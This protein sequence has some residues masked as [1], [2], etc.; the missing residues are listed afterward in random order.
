MQKLAGKSGLY[1]PVGRL[2]ATN[3]RFDR[4]KSVKRELVPRAIVSA[5]RRRV[6]QVGC[7]GL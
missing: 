4:Q 6:K 7:G 2:L 5:D 3:L 1:T